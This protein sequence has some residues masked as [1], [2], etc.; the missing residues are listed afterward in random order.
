[1]YLNC[2]KCKDTNPEMNL[3]DI[4]NNTE[5][6][7]IQWIRKEFTFEKGIER[8]ITTTKK[9][10][11]ESIKGTFS[12]LKE[13]FL[14]DLRAF[15]Q[16]FFNINHQHKKYREVIDN[17]LPNEAALIIDFS[18]NYSYTMLH[19]PSSSSNLEIVPIDIKKYDYVLSQAQ[20]RD[21]SWSHTESKQFE[22]PQCHKLFQRRNLLINHRRSHLMPRA[23]R[24]CTVCNKTFSN[25]SN[26]H[27]HKVIHTGLR[28]QK[29]EIC[30]KCFKDFATKKIHITYVHLKKPWPKRNRSKSAKT[31][32][33][34]LTQTPLPTSE[35]D[36]NTEQPTWSESIVRKDS[37]REY[38]DGGK[39]L[40]DLHADY[41]A[42]CLEQGDRCE[43]CVS[44]E[45]ANGSAKEELQEKYMLHQEE[46]D[47]SRIEKESDKNKAC[48]DYIVAV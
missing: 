23:K 40:A 48:N 30:G 35:S 13:M 33:A 37:S 8:K 7:W 18:E 38:I 4:T 2:E 29:C 10:A 46:K 45:N 31:R 16:H 42:Q 41:K 5:C 44:Y 27:R 19:Q 20:L 3:T 9:Y 15:R 39:C 28:N 22:C 34:T 43:L 14:A 17:L 12:E 32:Q 26:L 6:T 25:A 47:L 36:R 21:H 11:K 24:Q 1:M